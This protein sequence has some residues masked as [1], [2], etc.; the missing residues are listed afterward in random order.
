MVNNGVSEI[1]SADRD[2]DQVPLIK[3]IDPR[4]SGR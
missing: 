2:F 4:D 3:R 1:I